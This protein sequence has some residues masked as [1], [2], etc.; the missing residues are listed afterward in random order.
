MANP[1]SNL[2]GIVFPKSREEEAAEN[3][4]SF[5]PPIKTDGALVVQ[6]TPTG[7]VSGS[8]VNAYL[9]S[10]GTIQNE[11]DLIT[12]YEQMALNADVDQAIKHI[13]NEMV[14]NEDE[15]N[16]VVVNF[17]DDTIPKRIQNIIEDEFNYILNLLEFNTHGYEICR[18]WY[19]DG[20]IRYNAVVDRNNLSQGILELRLIEPRKIRKVREM[21]KVAD[22]KNKNVTLL[23]VKDEYYIYNDRGFTSTALK[24]DLTNPG[25]GTELRGLK[26]GKDSVV[27]STSGL[28]DENG[29]MVLSYLHFA[30]KPL[31][32]LRYMENAAVIYRLVRAPERRVFYIDVGDLPSAKAE[33][34][35]MQMQQQLKN[36]VQYDPSTGAITD[37]RVFSTFTQD[38]WF[39]RRNGSKGTEVDTLQGGQQIGE[40]GDVDYFQKKLYTSLNVPLGRLSPEAMNSFGIATE[41]SREEVNFSRF[42]DRI[43]SRFSQLFYN[44]LEKQLIYKGVMTADD[45]REIK[46]KIKFK[47]ARDTFYAELKNQEIT[48][49]RMETANVIM[50][51]VGRFY[52]NEWV[53]TNILNQTKEDIEEQDALIAQEAENPQYQQLIDAGGGMGMGNADGGSAISAPIGPSSDTEPTR[54][55]G[56]K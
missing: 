41:I 53:R 30:I 28:L 4:P 22:P 36:K 56:A 24:G 12:R 15:Q 25:S 26:I 14:V 43:R 37:A 23:R 46:H 55:S 47:F 32:D 20:R 29:K 21:E 31:N 8:F 9:D 16:A 2:W 45:W 44:I 39:A 40:M 6:A 13:V 49:A 38:F 52:S 3:T 42:I 48:K 34:K 5:I 19:I 11:A 18:K 27:E 33:Q 10:D 50:P 17:M 7:D 1:L 51:F 54:P 35:L